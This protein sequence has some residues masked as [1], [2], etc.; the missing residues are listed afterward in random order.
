MKKL[1]Q[2]FIKVQEIKFTDAQEGL[3][4]KYENSLDKFKEMTKL[5]QDIIKA[6]YSVEHIDL[7]DTWIKSIPH[8]EDQCLNCKTL[9]SNLIQLISFIKLDIKYFYD[10]KFALWTIKKNFM[11]YM[12]I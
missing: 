9:I 11:K 6:K 1:I 2:Q 5:F 3:Y 10:E 7:I 4:K 12:K 8:L